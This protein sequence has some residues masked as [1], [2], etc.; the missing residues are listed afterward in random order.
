MNNFNMSQENQNALLQM[1]AKKLGKDPNEL[2]EQLQ[3]GQLDSITKGMDQK[4]T[5]QI[6]ALLNNPKAL[7]TLLGN[8]KI[9]SMLEN[10]GK[11]QK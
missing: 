3:S 7:E 10:L 5:N 8:D 1:A 9:R 4:T 6:G 2:M 11:G